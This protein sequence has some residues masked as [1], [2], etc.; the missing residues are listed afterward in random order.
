[1]IIKIFH[2]SKIVLFSLFIIAT[3]SGC[4]D[5]KKPIKVSYVSPPTAFNEQ[6]GVIPKYIHVNKIVVN[7]DPETRQLI[8]KQA[9]AT[10]NHLLRGL[11]QRHLA[12]ST[13][14]RKPTWQ[15]Y[16][17]SLLKKKEHRG[18][19]QLQL[20]VEKIRGKG[21]PY[22][23]KFS[24]RS[25]DLAHAFITGHL[26]VSAY[27]KNWSEE[28]IFNLTKLPYKQKKL[29]GRIYM[30]PDPG[31]AK[32]RVELVDVPVQSLTVD[33]ELSL[34]LKRRSPENTG[35]EDIYRLDPITLSKTV[36]SDEI[37][38]KPLPS[39][40]GLLHAMLFDK[41]LDFVRAISNRTEMRELSFSKKGDKIAT[42][43]MAGGAFKEAKKRLSIV[44]GEHGRTAKQINP[45]DKHCVTAEA[46][47]DSSAL[48]IG[49]QKQTGQQKKLSKAE[50]K[51]TISH[52]ADDYFNL[53]VIY[54]IG[55]NINRAESLFKCAL[56][57]R[58]DTPLFIENHN[59][60]SSNLRKVSS[61][62]TLKDKESRLEAGT[63][64]GVINDNEQKL[65]DTNETKA[66]SKSE[67]K[68]KSPEEAESSD[69]ETNK[70]EQ[71]F[72][73]NETK[74]DSKSEQKYK[75]PEE[76]E[77][78][79]G[80]TNKYEQFFDTN[81]TKADS[82][83]EQKSESPIEAETSYEQFFDINETKTDFKSEQKLRKGRFKQ[84]QKL[85]D[86]PVS[87]MPEKHSPNSRSSDS[88]PNDFFTYGKP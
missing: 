81:E 28:R 61:F 53:G 18:R 59:R 71:F 34:T 16:P 1:M 23:T 48:P 66:D 35:L 37:N 69:G 30:L 33:A 47:K 25:N 29:M 13:V 22:E 42:T 44:V 51:K 77:S 21:L 57:L 75:S 11:I 3:I 32:L 36:H 26:K 10:V 46:I 8:G 73:T 40:L 50:Y 6:I 12:S 15:M 39:P 85:A 31:K 68:Y 45:G 83:S 78:S 60:L 14:E 86:P 84:K 76:A 87:N 82:K 41:T 49:N 19:K 79:D 62:K 38:R 64:E 58:P 70:Y 55:G 17:V 63:S 80:E 7:M 43:L 65:V 54:E 4:S 24:Y 56:E 72:D 9:D 52:M 20:L 5:K 2:L 67:Q 74:A 88:V 27:K